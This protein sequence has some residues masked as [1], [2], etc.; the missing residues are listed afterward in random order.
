V[1]NIPIFSKDNAALRVAYPVPEGIQNATY[2]PTI[3]ENFNGTYLNTT[4]TYSD[5]VSPMSAFDEVDDIEGHQPFYAL[6]A[7]DEEERQIWRGLGDCRLDWKGWATLQIERGD[8]ALVANYGIDI[9][10]LGFIEW[11]SDDSK[12]TMEGLWYDL[13]SKTSQYLRQVYSGNGWRNYVD[14][15]IGI[16]AQATPDD[17][18][19][20]PGKAPG[21]AYLDQGRIFILLKWQVYWMD[22]NIV[23][24]E[25]SHLFY[26]EDHWYTCCVM[27][28][29]THPQTW[30]W[31]D[32]L[33]GVFS[34]IHCCYTAYSWDNDCFTVID[35]HKSKYQG[36]LPILL[37]WW[38][39]YETRPMT[40]YWWFIEDTGG[41][42]IEDK[43]ANAPALRVK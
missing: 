2:I 18:E 27:A 9:R 29:H 34:D 30:I 36:D 42:W 25:V 5:M 40:R 14:A 13:E 32:G 37:D 33:W 15:I 38:D 39:V 21:P 8:E 24:H 43:G 41:T 35:Q 31:E 10:I 6:V 22:D 3:P 17:P 16:T 4:N 19:N 28:G 11:D 7:G 23:Q 20:W 12:T 26:A 1:S